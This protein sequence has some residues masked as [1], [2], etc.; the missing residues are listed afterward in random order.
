LAYPKELKARYGVAPSPDETD[1][2]VMEDIA[3]K[4]MLLTRGGEVDYARTSEMLMDEMKK[5]M[6]ANVSFEKPED[7]YGLE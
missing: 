2:S 5:N 3:H 7:F 6:F 4:R 1:L